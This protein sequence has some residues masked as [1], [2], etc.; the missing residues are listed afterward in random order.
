MPQLE[1]EELAKGKS[2]ETGKFL[3][4]NQFWRFRTRLGHGKRF[5]TGEELW[6]AACEY[7]EWNQNNP[8]EETKLFAYEGEVTA[9]TLPKVRAMSLRGL[10]LYLGVSTQSWN[11]WRKLRKELFE[12]IERIE[13]VIF[14]QK[15]EGASAG[16][17]NASIIARDLGL[18]D[19]T[20]Q[21]ATVNLTVASEDAEL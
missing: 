8:L 16:L 12:A 14:T 3:P 9:A 2:N 5:E 15:F 4:G 19:R 18:V 6:E 21:V 11:D 20:E 13:D 17:L 1:D 7:F 10:C